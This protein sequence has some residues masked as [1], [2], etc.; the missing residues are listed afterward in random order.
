[1]A[2]TVGTIGSVGTISRT[3]AA[4]RWAARTIGTFAV[5]VLT[6][7]YGITIAIVYTSAEVVGVKAFIV[8]VAKPFARTLLV[9][10]ASCR[11]CV[12]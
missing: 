11:W 4:V 7:G 10:V 3:R 9:K 8:G 12:A 6:A 1:M 5:A 2:N